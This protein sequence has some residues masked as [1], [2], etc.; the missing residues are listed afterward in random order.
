MLGFDLA[1]TKQIVGAR[2]AQHIDH[3]LAAY[4]FEWVGVA[5]QAQVEICR[6]VVE[7]LYVFAIGIVIE[8]FSKLTELGELHCPAILLFGGRDEYIARDR[9]AAV[10][11]FHPGIVHVFEGNGH[12]FMRDGDDESYDADTAADAWARMTSHFDEHLAS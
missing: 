11:A 10:E 7:V 2:C 4:K 6:V 3:R 8:A 12:A 9:V 1:G 5:T